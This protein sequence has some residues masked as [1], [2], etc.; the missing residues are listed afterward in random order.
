MQENNLT[1][2]ETINAITVIWGHGRNL[3]SGQFEVLDKS[4]PE[5]NLPILDRLLDNI[6]MLTEYNKAQRPAF[7]D[8]RRWWSWNYPSL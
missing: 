6:G 7:A 2:L 5:S 4:L 3:T 1:K 8:F